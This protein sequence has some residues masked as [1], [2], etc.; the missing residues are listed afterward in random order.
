MRLVPVAAVLAL[1]G[2]PSTQ[3]T[4]GDDAPDAD[5]AQPDAP[6]ATCENPVASCTLTIR[7]SGPGDSVS[8]RGDFAADGWTTG[9]AMTRDAT[10]WT[11]TI[12]VADEQIVVY[13]LVVDGTW[14]ADPD[15]PR[16]T[17]DGHGGSNSVVRVDC[18]RCPHRPAIDWRDAIIYFVMIDRF[19][20]GDP[21]NDAPVSGAEPPGQYKGGDLAG[22]RQAIDDGYFDGLGINTLWITSPFDNADFAYQGSD[23]H[24][25]SGYH[26]YWPKDL[27]AIESHAGTLADLRAVVDAAH[28]RGIQV[29]VD[30]VM[31]HVHSDSA[32]Y[33]QH[34]DWFWPND[35]GAG[36]NCICG[37]GCDWNSQ[38]IRCWFDPFLPDFDFRNSDA[39]RWSVDNAIGWAK[40]AGLD[41]FRLDA[42]KHIETS[43]LTDLRARLDGEVEWDQVFY[44]VGETFE[45]DRDVI[46]SYVDPETMLDGQFDFPLRA[47][48]LRTILRRQ[49]SMSDLANFLASNDTY[50]GPG[51]VMSTFL[52]NHDVPR[53]V[54]IAEDN[55]QWDEWA[56]GKERA[57]VNQPQLPQTA[58]AFERLAVGYALLYTSPGVPMLYYGDEYGMPGAGD[59][60]NRR[61]MQW[62]GHTP[63]QIWLRDQLA[64]F[65]RIRREHEA[66]RRGQRSTLGTTGDVYVYKMTTNGD[67]VFVVLNR[68]DD[69]EAAGGLPP[70]NYVDL[71]TGAPITAPLQAPARTAVLLKPS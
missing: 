69:A 26:G 7:Y 10:G 34:A 51:A 29:L 27:D 47:N 1:A 39:R 18:D 31:N 9:V 64:A 6:P 24:Q 20:N 56:G 38:R 36:G 41:G 28:A 59:P 16:T 65:A 35:N 21:S 12:D 3:A 14:I 19:A 49:G 37:H 50:Y 66:L 32:L 33:Q 17:P 43:W 70:G 23:G 5:P 62:S 11:A 71:I 60:D 68:G 54:H 48:V 8:L 13:K 30:Y 2:C 4:P 40:R 22:L 44:L 25:Y 53:V 46:K 52:G 45:G 57:W 67:A 55:P 15:N 58:S 63:N 61:F 42:V